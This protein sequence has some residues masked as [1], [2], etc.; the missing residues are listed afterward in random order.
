MSEKSELGIVG[1]GRMGANIARRLMRD[2]HRAVVYDVNADAIEELVGEGA[3][4][5]SSLEELASALSPPRAVWVMVP[6]GEITEKTV[7]DVAEHLQ[8]GD[9][10]ID[11]GN[12][13]YRD[14]IRRAAEL[15]D[16]GVDYI[17]CGT[18]GGVFGLELGY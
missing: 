4:G 12:T 5:A 11:G 7:A 9:A 3:D 2:G 18:S 15:T 17:D 13:Y 1:L 16:R 14:D 10:V 8:K 6:A